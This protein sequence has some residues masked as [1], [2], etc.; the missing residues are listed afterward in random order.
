M[1]ETDLRWFIGV[2]VTVVLALVTTIIAAF[3]NLAVR[4]S[5]SERDMLKRIDDVKEKYVRRDDLDGHITR[6]DQGMREIRE[7]MRENHTQVIEA[8]RK[9]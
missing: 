5:T 2:A 1:M 8:I 3:R 4:I 6:L 7:E 9:Q